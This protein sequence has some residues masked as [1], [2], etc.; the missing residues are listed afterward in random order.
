[1]SSATNILGWREILARVMDG[2]E[3]QEDVSPAWL[4]NPATN[5]P[6]KLNQ[7]YPEVGL[8]IRFVGLTAK[9]QPRQSDEEAQSEAERDEIRAELCRQND[10]ELLLLDPDYPHPP[11]QFQRF[12]SSLSRLSRTLAQSDR[13]EEDK[14]AFMPRLADA[15]SRLDDI[16]RRVRSP[17]D[18][19][20]FADLWRDR[21]ADVFAAARQATPVPAGPVA[22]FEP[23]QVV[24]HERYGKG[25]VIAVAGGGADAQVTVHFADD[26]QRTFLAGLVAGK[27]ALQ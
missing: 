22:S 20:L 11:E 16:S 2:F 14:L 24:R 12:R 5:R 21:E 17:E 27:L 9:R 4:V 1:M 18:L 8:A 25:A 13:P 10:A 26:S 23:G 15:R 3:R 19:A 6:L 7:F